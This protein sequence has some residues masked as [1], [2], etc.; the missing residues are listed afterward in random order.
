M[1][2][3]DSRHN[4][5]AILESWAQFVADERG[6]VPP[7]RSVPQVTRFLLDHLDWIAEQPPA[8]D[9]ADEIDALHRELLRTIDPEPGEPAALTWECVV[10]NCPGRISTSARAD[11]GSIRCSAGH[12]WDMREWITLRPLVERRRKAVDA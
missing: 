3:L 12:T 9:F 10:A 1:S 8:A 2:A 4:L 5:L 11:G 7:A 6:A